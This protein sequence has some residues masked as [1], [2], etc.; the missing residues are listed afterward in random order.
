MRVRIKEDLPLI[1][2]NQKLNS[3][4][5]KKQ[6]LTNGYPDEPHSVDQNIMDLSSQHFSIAERL[7]A[8][9]VCWMRA[10]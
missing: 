2:N 6:R 10:P 9:E 3:V 4:V 1:C 8:S 7:E 5:A